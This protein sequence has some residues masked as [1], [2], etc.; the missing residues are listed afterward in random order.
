[1]LRLPFFVVLATLLV[2]G[3]ALAAADKL[4]PYIEL[5]VFLGD[6]P[7]GTE[8]LRRLVAKEASYYSTHS[9]LQDKVN[10]VWRSFTERSHLPLDAKGE[11]TQYD[12]W[13]DVTGATSSAK[14]FNFNGQWRIATTEAAIDGKKPKPR[15]TDVKLKAPFVVLDERLPSLVAVAAERMAGKAEF[16]YVR[17]D[18]A[19]S[20]RLTMSSEAL[21]DKAGARY[22]RIRMKG[23]GVELEVLRDHAGR[24]LAIKGLDKWRAV[25]KDTKVPKDLIAA[26]HE[27][28]PEAKEP[29]VPAT[30]VPAQLPPTAT[31]T[32]K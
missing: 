10:K 7:V 19:T 28:A 21:Q 26:A 13:I 3:P 25:A 20:G 18:D 14:L 27:P 30:Q 4:K 6:K 12:R 1:M 32:G 5:Q 22:H 8:T 2:A 16:D 15:V 29:P 11:I 24:V 23:T 9:S 17:V 31:P